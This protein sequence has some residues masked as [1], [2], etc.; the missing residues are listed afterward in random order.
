MA[1]H[2]PIGRRAAALTD[3]R[4]ECEVLR[5][6]IEAVRGGASRALVVRGEPGVGKTALLEYLVE[7]A[8]GC[9]VLRATG[10]QSEMELAFAG[11]HQLLAP[12]LDRLERVPGPQRDA[13]RMA[14][15]IDRGSTPDRFFVALAVL[16]LLSDVAEERPLICLVDDAQWIDRA[17]VQVLGFVARRLQAESVY[18]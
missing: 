11:A 8:S 14:F 3:R 1:P 9:R 5:R 18:R 4:N 10:V 12:L 2:S 16:G 6:L 13:L 17:S 7:P 15:G